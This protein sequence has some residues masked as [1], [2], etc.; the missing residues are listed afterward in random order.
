M[1]AVRLPQLAGQSHL[2]AQADRAAVADGVVDEAPGHHAAGAAQGVAFLCKTYPAFI[3]TGVAIIAVW[4]DRSLR[5]RQL[6]WMLLAT[7]IAIA[8]WCIWCL[9]HFP[10][11]FLF[12]QV[13][14]FR[15]L[16]TNVENW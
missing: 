8:P 11:E 16:G 15:H 13:Q 9:I 1:A 6:L 3:V 14:V 12:E 4:W 7:I 10:R 2:A 5:P